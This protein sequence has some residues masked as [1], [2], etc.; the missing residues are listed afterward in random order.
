M[1]NTTKT[2]LKN[3]LKS[4]DWRIKMA[5]NRDDDVVRPDKL[6]NWLEQFAREE[7]NRSGDNI[8][9]SKDSFEAKVRELQEKVGLNAISNLEE[10]TIISTAE[11]DCKV[12]NERKDED[13]DAEQLKKGI[14]IELEHTK[15]KELAKSIAMD[16]LDEHPRYYEF[17]T[18]MEKEMEAAPN[19]AAL[20]YS[21]VA[22]AN[23]LDD[24]GDSRGA[25]IIDR[26]IAKYAEDE[27]AV[28]KKNPKMKKF[29][30]EL[31]ESRGGFIDIPALF[32]ILKDEFKDDVDIHDEGL[33]GHLKDCLKK[34]KKET[35]EKSDGV[36]K[37]FVAVF[38]LSKDDETA[39]T[40]V[41]HT[42]TKK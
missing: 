11:L 31:C 2:I 26:H 34:T 41:F 12:K 35:G 42:P 21:L 3:I 36:G 18:K 6:P 8:K 25:Q 13:Y 38:E 5:V 4:F 9:N 28:F 40:E 30:E 14:E 37:G 19:K 10:D 27:P 32:D 15:D 7:M 22:F 23:A 39:N 33:K 20:V 16:H 24:I 1:P 17:L 29:I